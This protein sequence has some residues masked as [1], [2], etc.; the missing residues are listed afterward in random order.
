MHVG[1]Y[2]KNFAVGNF[3]ISLCQI[4]LVVRISDVIVND[5]CTQET[6]STLMDSP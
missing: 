6:Q 2:E 3:E 4:Y 5:N 1:L